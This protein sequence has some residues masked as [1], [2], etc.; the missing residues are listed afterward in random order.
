MGE[1]GGG[2]KEVFSQDA[3]SKQSLE[4]LMKNKR[5][6]LGGCWRVPSRKLFFFLF[7]F[8]FSREIYLFAI[9]Y[10]HF[11]DKFQALTVKQQFF[12]S[13]AGKMNFFLPPT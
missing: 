5:T 4:L 2:G 3:T 9:F 1:G 11:R 10:L 12:Y 7:H 8:F 13:S 6:F